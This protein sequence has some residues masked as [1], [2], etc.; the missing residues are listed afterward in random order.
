MKV[1]VNGKPLADVLTLLEP[2]VAH[3]NA[4]WLQVGL[5]NLLANSGALRGV[6]IVPASGA[7][8]FGLQLPSGEQV[9]VA[10]SGGN[11]ATVPALD[12]AGGYTG[13]LLNHAGENYWSEYWGY[14]K[15]VYVRYAACV[16]MPTRPV[17]QFI[18][19]TLALIDGNPVE[20]LVIDFRNNGGGS[21]GTFIPLVTGIEQRL[22]TLRA[23]PQFRVYTLIN[24]ATFS[25]AMDGAEDLK[26]N[27]I[28]PTMTILG[29]AGSAGA[30]S[31][32]VGE[33]TGGKP[34]EYGNVSSFALPASRLSFF[35]STQ[36]FSIMAGIPDL[37]A[38]YPD[39]AVNVRSTDYFA[40]HDAVLAA[41]LAHASAPPAA[42]GGSAIVVNSA[43][44]RYETGIAAGSLA[45]AFGDYPAGDLEI[46]VNGANARVL[47]ATST[48]IV[49]VVP[50]QTRLG[51]AGLQ[52]IRGGSVVSDGLFQVTAAG[53]GLF[54]A[55]AA[56]AAQP[57]A[58]LN[59]DNVL[60]SAAAPAAAGSTVQI[61]ATG[62]GPVDAS[63]S[64]TVSVWIANRPAEVVY[65]GPAP[66]VDGLWQINVRIPAD[67]AITNQVPLF[68]SAAG[69]VS[70]GVTIYAG[71]P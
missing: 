26:L 68:I 35:C 14:A 31:I 48:Q 56:N 55:A 3:D 16:E 15:T 6:G 70:N 37:D 40:R 63:G 52:V 29:A 18:A 61:F 47:G 38:V 44:Y 60:N 66:G 9:T 23:N 13:P 46:T 41:A 62:Y 33:P 54:V 22:R 69:L 32:L 10:L 8:P 20:T 45:S 34:A 53:P 5:A 12:P 49:F 1:H 27:V 19:D 30:A 4:G 43:S 58:V 2:L 36:Y 17:S 42:P 57:G 51:T 11:S 71:K 39:V 65:S 21:D 24:H 67:P 28:P 59:Q 64:A 25:S 7:I 50:P